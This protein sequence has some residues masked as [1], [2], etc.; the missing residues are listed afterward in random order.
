MRCGVSHP[1]PS[2]SIDCVPTL[3]TTVGGISIPKNSKILCVLG[4]ANLDEAHWSHADQFDV[5]RKPVGHLALGVGVHQCVGQNVARAEGEAVLAA[6]HALDK[7]PIR[8]VRAD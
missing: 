8:F 2:S 6:I 5:A 1:F 4:S 7:M 3:D